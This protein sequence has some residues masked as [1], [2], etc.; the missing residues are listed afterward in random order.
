MGRNQIGIVVK[1]SVPEA[2]KLAALVERYLKKKYKLNCIRLDTGSE[3]E[4]SVTT[5]SKLMGSLKLIIVLGGDGTF[6]AAARMLAAFNDHCQNTRKKSS[7]TIVPILGVNMGQLG[8]LTEVKKTEILSVLDDV[9]SENR[10]ITVSK[11]TLMRCRVYRNDKI[12]LEAIVLND[13]V[14]SRGAIARIFDLRVE[15]DQELIS[16]FKADGVL[17]STPTGS[18]A[19][20]LAVGGPIVH[21]DVPAF[22]IAPICPHSLTLRPL[23]VSD[24]ATIDIYPRFRAGTVILTL[25]GQSSFVLENGDRVEV[26]RCQNHKLHILGTSSRNYFSILREKLKFGSRE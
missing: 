6:L 13:I 20:G 19:Y 3:T 23:I 15:L 21:P 1:H 9:V 22:E 11:R 5:H 17:V 7:K 12:R 8:F 2:E 24:R 25:D 16:E 26:T 10:K 14:I 4:S 18:T